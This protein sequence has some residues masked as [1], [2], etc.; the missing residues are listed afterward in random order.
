MPSKEM[1]SR[2]PC[3][4]PTLDFTSICAALPYYLPHPPEPEVTHT[5]IDEAIAAAVLAGGARK[6][7][8]LATDS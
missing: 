8:Y 4:R 6:R 2:G 3:R 7:M 1:A 5:S